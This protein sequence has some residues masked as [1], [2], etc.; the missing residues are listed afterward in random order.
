MPSIL[1][2][3][4]EKHC[5]GV[6]FTLSRAY[7]DRSQIGSRNVVSILSGM[8]LKGIV[9]LAILLGGLLLRT[10]A[11]NEIGTNRNRGNCQRC[12]Q[13]APHHE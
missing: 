8:S 12:P 13:N 7:S 1:C 9:F 3:A 2:G 6:C 10:S 11:P 5:Q 4:P